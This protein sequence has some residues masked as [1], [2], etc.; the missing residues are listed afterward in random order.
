MVKGPRKDRA[1]QVEKR[2]K[3]GGKILYANTLRLKQRGHPRD[4]MCDLPPLRSTNDHR[5]YSWQRTLDK[6]CFG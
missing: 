5:E 1:R 4:G 3:A 2:K 6:N